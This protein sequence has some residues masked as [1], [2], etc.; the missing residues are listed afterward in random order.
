[1]H[2][3]IFLSALVAT[4]L[5]L[6]GIAGALRAA[7]D[8]E[9]EIK[10]YREMIDDPMANP[11]YLNVD[12]GESLWALAR[13][14]KNASLETCDLGKGAGVLEGAYAELP[15]YFAD[16][17]VVMDLE[18]RLLWCM[19]QVQGLDTEEILSRK[20]GTPGTTSDLEDL[21]AYIANKSSGM[22]FHIPL[23]DPQERE[24]YAIGEALF[25]RRGSL[26]DFSCA[27]CHSADGARIR[28]T[29]LPNLTKPG[30]DARETMGS[31]PTYRVSQS[32]TRTM[33]NRLWDCYRQMRMPPPEF[34]SA[35]LTALMIYLAKQADG[36]TLN[37]PSIKR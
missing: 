11:A 28:T 19:E 27:T 15:R 8:A 32:Q 10:R 3:R 29:Q 16:A 1:M 21:V 33:Q 7:E 4:V 18:Q 5:L 14:Q 31:W 24:A 36:G 26:L 9:E 6:G 12:R 30:P 37:V 2:Q 22:T 17:D 20:F 23:D 35:G 34:G 13:G 25:Y